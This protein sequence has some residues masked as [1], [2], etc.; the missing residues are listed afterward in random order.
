MS[1]YQVIDFMEISERDCK[2]LSFISAQSHHEIQTKSLFFMPSRMFT[3]REN[4]RT[5]TW[6]SKEV[7][8]GDS[9]YCNGPGISGN[10]A[11]LILSFGED[12]SGKYG[13]FSLIIF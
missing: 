6:T 8:M 5:K 11:T 1:D 10:Y 4:K 7:C 9:S 12:E 3:L 13:S 2:N